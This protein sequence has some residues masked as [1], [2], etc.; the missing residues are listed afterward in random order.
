[1]HVLM[2]GREA[3]LDVSGIFLATKN[4]YNSKCIEKASSKDGIIRVEHVND[5]K[6]HVLC[7][8]VLW[9]TKGNM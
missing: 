5:I 9:G 6:G 8:R 4:R 1:M 3:L 7:V 2:I